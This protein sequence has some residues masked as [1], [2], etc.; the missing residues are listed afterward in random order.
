MSLLKMLFRKRKNSQ[1]EVSAKPAG[2]SALPRSSESQPEVP[3]KQPSLSQQIAV[4]KGNVVTNLT[5]YPLDVVGESNYQHVFKQITDGYR[6]DSQAIEISAIIALDPLNKYDPYA[7]RVEISNQI[8]GY[9]PKVEAQRIGKMMREQGVEKAGVQA[10]IRGGWRTN[11]HDIGHFGVK[12]RMPR[13]GWIDFGVGAK[14]P[15]SNAAPSTAPAM[16]KKFVPQPAESGP[17]SYKCVVLWGLS[18]DEEI[19]RKIAA[20]GGRVMA[21]VGK[22]TNLVVT[23]GPLT[24][25]MTRSATWR[26]IEELRSQGHLIEVITWPE[27]RARIA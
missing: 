10:Q 18:K 21:A 22:S 14:D 12:L 13:Y 26:K 24:A 5:G 15:G 19:V 3:P 27:L 6:R 4:S 11:Q 25:G 7:V 2:L 1:N 20:A 9:L 23:E 16:A 8:V 17:L